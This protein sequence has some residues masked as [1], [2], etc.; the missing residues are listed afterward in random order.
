MNVS[1]LLCLVAFALLIA[2]C[3][4]IVNEGERI[5]LFRL[6]RYYRTLGPGLHFVLWGVDVG[7]RVVLDETLPGWSGMSEQQLASR[8]E[9]LATSGQLAPRA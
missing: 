9:Q 4:K 7:R 1:A 5:V 2:M 8:L 3:L 6:G